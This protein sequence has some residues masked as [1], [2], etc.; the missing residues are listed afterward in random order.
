M[1]TSPPSSTYNTDGNGLPFFQGKAEFTELS[2]VP[3][4][5]CT[6]P[7]RIAKPNDVLLSVRAPVG[8][9]N[10]A[11]QECCFGRGLAAIRFENY[12][13]LFYFLK[14]ITNKLD[15]QGTG[16]TFRAISAGVVKDTEIP[17][18]PMEEQE[19][20]V[21]KIEE[22]FSELDAGVEGLKKAQTQLKTYRQS[23][24]K[25]AFEGRL[26][27]DNVIDG[28]LPDGWKSTNI[29]GLVE[30][31]SDG[32][33]GSNLKGADY[34]SEGVR[35]IRLEN[36][37]YL[38][39]RDELESYV[40]EEKY[41]TISRYTVGQGDIIFSSFIADEIRVC[42]LP[43]H[44]D[45]AINKADCF[46]IRVDEKKVGRKYLT[47]FLSSRQNYLQLVDNIHGATR[48]RINTTQLKTA[49]VPTCSLDE[50][51]RIVAEIE[52]RLSVC[53][54]ME[55]AIR[56]GLKQSEALRQSILKKAFEGRLVPQAVVTSP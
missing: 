47:Y 42:I 18:P 32:P 54:K 3:R 49:M 23:V 53:D 43:D 34:V 26:T 36:V 29:G 52:S 14:S 12:K 8:T 19:R 38:E 15:E 17:L 46:L 11:N 2:P 16:T 5:W 20:I 27:N 10:I 31:I 51:Q 35:V 1:G 22:L 7:A 48:P 41:E 21:A 28:E 40:T 56:V 13:Y 25:H 4:K 55:E 45:R 50:Q 6:S 33:F 9:V 39:F 30:R 44:I 24:L 37:G